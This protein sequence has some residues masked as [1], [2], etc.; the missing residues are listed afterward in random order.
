MD[1]N[2]TLLFDVCA[3]FFCNANVSI[4]PLKS[5]PAKN[6]FHNNSEGQEKCCASGAYIHSKNKLVKMTKKNWSFECV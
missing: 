5:A 4:G 3:I 2:S 1:I 6:T